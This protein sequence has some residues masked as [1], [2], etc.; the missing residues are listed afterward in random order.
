M[1][2]KSLDAQRKAISQAISRAYGTAVWPVEIS[3]EYANRDPREYVRDNAGK[4]HADVTVQKLAA[5][6][7]SRTRLHPGDVALASTIA[8][9][10][11]GGISLDRQ[12]AA[13]RDLD[14]AMA[15]HR[16]KRARENP[17]PSDLKAKAR[18]DAPTVVRRGGGSAIKVVA[19]PKAAQAIASGT[20]V[21]YK[22]LDDDSI[23]DVVL[24][25]ESRA[26]SPGSP[27]I[28]A[29]SS[30]LGRA[31][32]G[33]TTGTIVSAQLGADAVEIEVLAVG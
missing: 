7:L 27:R 2:E 11:D 15:L 17:L 18:K 23:H 29:T 22:R 30:P 1:S 16:K 25:K 10:V 4:P 26:A 14:S 19:P 9:L 6:A 5:L 12:A 32:L 3:A 20:R 28:V 33:A 24:G 13:P 31:L 8:D 21:R